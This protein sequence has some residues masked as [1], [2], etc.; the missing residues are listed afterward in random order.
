MADTRGVPYLDLNREFN[1]LKDE[2]FALL[3]ESGQRGSW[4]LGPNVHAFEE[5]V[6]A[7]VGTRHAIG[8][9]NGTDALYLALRAL[10]I[11]TGD[12][13]ITTPYTFFATAEV[14]S[15][16]GATPVFVDIQADSFNIDPALVE[17]AVTERTR[18]IMPVH[19]FGNPVDMAALARIAE[20]R[21]IALVEDAA[22]AFGAM[23]GD[24]RV[25]SIGA[26]GCFSFYPTK[27]LGCYGDGGLLTTDS[28]DVAHHVRKLR[29]H[30]ASAAFQ[31]DE[32]GMNSRLDEVQAALLRIKLKNVDQN[33]AQ[34]QRV[35][36]A[37]DARLAPLGIT[38]PARPAHGHHAFN[39]Y[40]IRSPQ[41]DALRAA[42]IEHG[43]GNS[44]C[45]PV[46]LAMQAVYADLGYAAGNLPVAEQMGHEVVSLPIYPDLS[47]SQ[48][49]T[50]CRV[51][52]QAIG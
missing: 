45:Y 41:R 28:D 8:L 9:A 18:A 4:I 23:V 52:E 15:M 42:L 2:W 31:H 19:L 6:A 24:R 11:G 37:Y 39:L 49:D 27:V 25:G 12:E 7:H 29:N 22:Q 16:V 48:I 51:I 20:D 40:T 32:V 33:I 36:N 50:V 47:E 17:R 13:V 43:I 46:P 21:G 38:C 10:G 35:A 3:G 5:E 1:E 44:T 30:G 14:I 26:V 34:R